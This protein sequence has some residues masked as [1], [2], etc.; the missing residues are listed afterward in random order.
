M[1]YVVSFL[2]AA[3]LVPMAGMAL[4]D[5]YIP[6][7]M[8]ALTKYYTTEQIT[9]QEWLVAITYMHDNDIIR[10]GEPDYNNPE[11]IT[12]II[13]RNID[14]NTIEID[15]VRIR[16]PLVDVEDSGDMTAP[17]AVLARL[18]CPVGHP[19]QYDIDD[20]Q[21]QDRY[22]RTIASVYCNTAISLGE[23]MIKFG[24]G[25]INQWYCDKSEFERAAWTQGT[26][27]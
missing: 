7:A 15:G 2:V 8:P 21:V 24:L 14:G 16:I 10:L 17:H 1:L 18:F 26:C 22:G 6:E 20:H 13:T 23:I 5:V 19:A 12:G 4:A 9:Q 25:W 3:A 27:W 11:I